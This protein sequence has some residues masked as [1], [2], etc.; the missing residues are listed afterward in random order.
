MQL[1]G[2]LQG[3]SQVVGG[4][5]WGQGQVVVGEGGSGRKEQG[6]GQEGE[7]LGQELQCT[8]GVAHWCRPMGHGHVGEKWLGWVCLY[9]VTHCG[10]RWG[11]LVTEIFEN[12]SGI[13][14]GK[15]LE[16]QGTA[17]GWRWGCGGTLV[18][19]VR[20]FH[21]ESLHLGLLE[22]TGQEGLVIH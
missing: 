21:G 5:K 7:G 22:L 15:M 9:L 17:E 4:S 6:H 2:L 1:L 11:F 14:E 3:L 20:M 13:S 12:G 16:Y 8:M 19:W 18:V 10:V